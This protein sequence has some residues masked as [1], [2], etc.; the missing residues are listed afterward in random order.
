MS[1]LNS[2]RSLLVRNT[3]TESTHRYD[4]AFCC[5]KLG[6]TNQEGYHGVEK[7]AVAA[8]PNALKP[9]H[10]SWIW[11]HDPEQYAIENYEKVD[12]CLEKGEEW[13]NTKIPP[14]Y[15]PRPWSIDELILLQ[16]QGKP[17]ELDG[18]WD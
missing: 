7:A 17:I 15:V 13:M 10:R 5:Q 4:R 8:N 2:G 18:D 9:R 14:G 11:K 16:E 3:I 12:R 1:S 6:F